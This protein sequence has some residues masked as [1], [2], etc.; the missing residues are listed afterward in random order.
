MKNILSTFA[1]LVAVLFT[2]TLSASTLPGGAQTG[3]APQSSSA[4]VTLSIPQ[5]IGVS[6][7]S[8]FVLDFNSAS[9]CWGS[10]SSQGTF[11]QSPTGQT[12]Y[13]FAASSAPTSNAANVACPS[14][15]PQSDSGA[16][17]IYSNIPGSTGHLQTSLS[18]GGSGAQA[19]KFSDLIADVITAGRLKLN[20]KTG[21]CG[22]GSI[23]SPHA[24]TVAAADYVTAIPPTGWSDC[25]Q[26]LSLTLDAATIVSAGTATGTLVFTMVHP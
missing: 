2:C 12:V 22:A 6:V 19:A 16:V 17:S 23:A 8:N 5:S 24:L 7:A 13:T 4:L 14:S 10:G 26:S 15:G 25:S 18:D 1:V 11:P 9:K 21:A 3:A 20:N